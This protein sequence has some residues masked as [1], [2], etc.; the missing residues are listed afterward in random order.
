MVIARR[1][2]LLVQDG[3]ALSRDREI[4]Y[5]AIIRDCARKRYHY[6]VD[7]ALKELEK[8]L[9]LAPAEVQRAADKGESSVIRSFLTDLGIALSK[10]KAAAEFFREQRQKLEKS[11]T[12]LRLQ[13]LEEAVFGKEATGY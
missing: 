12:E 4:D 13:A 8:L 7:K 9:V 5:E 1:L 10:E 2:L 11:I 6:R 3:F